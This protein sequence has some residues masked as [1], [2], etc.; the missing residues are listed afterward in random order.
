MSDQTPEAT[1]NGSVPAQQ[2]PPMGSDSVDYTPKLPAAVRR[3]ARRAEELSEQINRANEES[4]HPVQEQV[5]APIPVQ[6]QGHQPELP[7]ETPV[8]PTRPDEWVQRYKT[9]QGKYDREV[10]QLRGQVQSLEQL[11]AAMRTAPPAP[12]PT[13]SLT[14]QVPEEDVVAYGPEL[15]GS[16]QNW[17]EARMAP[18]VDRLDRRM[19]DLEQQLSEQNALTARE[20]LE[21]EFDLDPE[22]APHWQ[23]LNHDQDFMNWLREPDPFSGRPRQLMLNDACAQGDAVRTGRFFKAYLEHTAPRQLPAYQT[24]TPS[25]TVVAGSGNLVAYAAPGRSHATPDNGA[26]DQR[27]WTNRE[28]QTFFDARL[29]GRYRGR[30]VESE[31]LERQIFAAVNE[32]RVRNV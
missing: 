19:H 14:T 10:P 29:K 12:P 18:H 4:Q 16:A 9:L 20:R 8:Q 31:Q 23:R 6:E 25:S 3:A 30:E 24:Q 21:R 5:P 32:G 22:L 17:S 13:A 28:I 11:I 15:I 27:I 1:P 7:L 2:V 26:P